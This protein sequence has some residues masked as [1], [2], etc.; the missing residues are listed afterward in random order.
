MR[1]SSGSS[2]WKLKPRPGLELHRRDAEVGQ[3]AVDLR[4]RR[5]CRARRRASGSP[6]GRARRDR[7]T[8]R[9]SCARRGE[10]GRIA[11]EA[12][13]PRG[14]GF[15]QRA[16]V[17]AETDR[18]VDE[19][20]AALGLQEAQRLG[21]QHGNVGRSNA[22]LRERARV[23]VGVRFALQ[24]RQEAIVIPDVEIVDLAEHVDVA[25]SSWRHRAGGTESARAPARR[26]RRLPEVVHAIEEAQL[27]RD[28]I[29]GIRRASA[30]CRARRASG[31]CGRTRPSGSSERA[32]ARTCLRAGNGRHSAP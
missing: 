3:R 31:R 19:Q 13:D 29:D 26:A 12:D 23:V 25:A 20:A 2:R 8:A 4:R 10:G 1:M 30:R 9:A 11:I 22:E 27:R 21:G 14:A 32:H 16:R 5:G 24:T 17:A 6:R 7:P 18:A 15:E 28:A